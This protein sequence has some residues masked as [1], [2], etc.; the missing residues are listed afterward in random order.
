MSSF[1]T[2]KQKFGQI[3]IFLHITALR[4]IF[5]MYVNVAVVIY[6]V[7]QVTV[8]SPCFRLMFSPGNIWISFILPQCPIL[9]YLVTLSSTLQGKYGLKT[10][11]C[12]NNLQNM[13]L[14]Y[15]PICGR[16]QRALQ[17]REAGTNF[18]PPVQI[19]QCHTFSKILH[20]QGCLC[21]LRVVS[22]DSDCTLL[23]LRP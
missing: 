8:K 18:P 15:V 1:I 10:H 23:G 4:L 20:T 13:V 22:R 11:T 5:V 14:Q 19:Y 17:R 2:A 21:Q 7:L 12:T 6:W 9:L 16:S 3:I